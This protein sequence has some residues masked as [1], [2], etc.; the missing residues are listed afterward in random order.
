MEAL[1]TANPISIPSALVDSEV[2]RLMQTARQDMEQQRHE[3]KDFPSSQNGS[4]DQTKAPRDLGLILSKLVAEKLH[5][6]PETN[7]FY[8]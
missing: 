3:N 8:G 6:T 5:A 4:L 2:Q 1:I 7:S